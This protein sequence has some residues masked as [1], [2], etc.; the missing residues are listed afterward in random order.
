VK[1]NESLVP[2][3]LSPFSKM[4]R[5]MV[6]GAEGSY[7]SLRGLRTSVS[8]VRCQELNWLALLPDPS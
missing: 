4:G 8:N 2:S 6:A 7:P 1:E 3:G 5:A